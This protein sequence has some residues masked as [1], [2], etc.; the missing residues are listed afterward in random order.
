MS[1]SG[2]ATVWITATVPVMVVAEHVGADDERPARA[3][4]LSHLSAIY[5]PSA[6]VCRCQ[7]GNYG[8]DGRGG[9]YGV[10]DRWSL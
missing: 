1:N 9:G 2:P 10:A 6:S 5:S 4:P 8:G 7:C 3:L